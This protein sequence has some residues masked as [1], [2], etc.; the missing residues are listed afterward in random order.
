M[1]FTTKFRNKSYRIFSFLSRTDKK[2]NFDEQLDSFTEGIV[3]EI[4][5][6]SY[7]KHAPSMKGW[8]RCREKEKRRLLSQEERE[9]IL[10][11]DGYHIYHTIWTVAHALHTAYTLQAQRRA[12][13]NRN[14]SG[15]QQLQP[16]QLHPFLHISQHY[17]NSIEGVYLDE[18][19]DLAADFDITY[20]V[21]FPNWTLY[22]MN[23]GSL[24]RE[25]C[26]EG[27]FKFRMDQNAIRRA[28]QVDEVLMRANPIQL[29][30]ISKLS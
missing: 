8:T 18:K 27:K 2:I 23:V 3:D 24:E 11:M 21:R 19:G 20:W 16:W 7:S 17:N 14:R 22:K 4:Y 29:L 12:T 5:S 25:G 10:S 13:E 15:V 28:M 6:C 9:R 30:H 26:S 1:S